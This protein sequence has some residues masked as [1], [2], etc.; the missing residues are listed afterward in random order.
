ML[1]VVTIRTGDVASDAHI[2]DE[3]FDR[4]FC[5]TAIPGWMAEEMRFDATRNRSPY[6]NKQTVTCP[7]CLAEWNSGRRGAYVGYQNG[8]PTTLDPNTPGA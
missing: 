5:T 1:H 2:L 4:T 6:I 8:E 3:G 7:R